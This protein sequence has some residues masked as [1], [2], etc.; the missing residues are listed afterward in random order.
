[1]HFGGDFSTLKA[2]HFAVMCAL[3]FWMFACTSSTSTLKPAQY[4]GLSEI[5]EVPD[6]ELM[7]VFGTQ[8]RTWHRNGVSTIGDPGFIEVEDELETRG[9]IDFDAVRDI[10]KGIIYVGMPQSQALASFPVDLEFNRIARRNTYSDVADPVKLLNGLEVEYVE[11]FG[12]ATLFETPSMFKSNKPC[13]YVYRGKGHP[14]MLFS[15]GV[16]VGFRVSAVAIEE[17]YS[18]VS[19]G[20]AKYQTN[21]SKAD[22]ERIEDLS[23]TTYQYNRRKV[24]WKTVG[25]RLRQFGING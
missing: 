8:L 19:A 14:Y 18:R 25:A 4:S 9:L 23:E 20:I 6:A 3:I 12:R 22:C 24:Q 5:T 21:F 15:D 11:Y 7:K 13:G 2:V 17:D 1:M 16:L 10:R